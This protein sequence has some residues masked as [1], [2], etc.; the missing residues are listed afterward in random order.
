MHS[1][2]AQSAPSIEDLKIQAGVMVT[3]QLDR[4]QAQTQTEL[5]QLHLKLKSIRDELGRLSPK[6]RCH[7]HRRRTLEIQMTTLEATITRVQATQVLDVE[8][9][10]SNFLSRHVDSDATTPDTPENSNSPVNNPKKPRIEEPVKSTKLTRNSV[11]LTSADHNASDQIKLQIGSSACRR[12][13][14]SGDFVFLNT[15]DDHTLA[16]QALVQQTSSSINQQTATV[17]GSQTVCD[18][19]GT[20][21]LDAVSHRLVCSECRTETGSHVTTSNN[22]SAINVRTRY[23]R[24]GYFQEMHMIYCGHICLVMKNEMDAVVALLKRKGEPVTPDNVFLAGKQLDLS[25]VCKYS[26]GLAQQITGKPQGVLASLSQQNHN[27]LFDRF[28][29]ATCAFDRLKH[30]GRFMTRQNLP[31]P[32]FYFRL[33]QLCSWSTKKIVDHF[34]LPFSRPRIQQ[35]RMWEQVCEDCAQNG[36]S[37]YVW[38][39]PEK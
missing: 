24:Q 14:Q 17:V 26:V 15:N 13:K 3:K 20:L 22:S 30:D 12:K 18:C 6:L 34:R 31:Y 39:I 33:I 7:I 28:N 21:W 2:S 35:I 27:E 9:K 11:T 8:T 38:L 37:K 1:M 23:E 19:G 36:L 16:L 25:S 4:V 29:V 5:K 10:F 32:F